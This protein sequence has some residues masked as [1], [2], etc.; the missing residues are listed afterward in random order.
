MSARIIRCLWL[1][2]DQIRAQ[3]NA[4][5]VDAIRSSLASCGPE[6]LIHPSVVVVAPENVRIGEHVLVGPGGWIS[7][8]NTSINNIGG[9]VMMAPQVALVAG[10]HNTSVVGRFMDEV[11]EKRPEDDQPIVIEDDVWL[12]MRAIVLKGVTIGRGSVV[13]AGSVVTHDVAPYSVVAG[14]PA[15]LVRVRFDREQVE[16]H[17]RVL[18]SQVIT[19]TTNPDRPPVGDTP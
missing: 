3:R 2:W 10:N 12:G 8:V 9:H 13:S 6:T 5:V 11:D 17:E 16:S 7:A 4:Q 18:Y 15:R 1:V 19:M 14:V